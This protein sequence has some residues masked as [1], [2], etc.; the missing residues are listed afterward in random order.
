VTTGYIDDNFPVSLPLRLKEV[1]MVVEDTPHYQ[2]DDDSEWATLFPT[3]S[4]FVHL[5]PDYVPFRLSMFHQLHCL[6]MTRT[7]LLLILQNKSIALPKHT[8]HCLDYLRQMALCAADVHLEPVAPYLLKLG[9]DPSG[10]HRCWDWSAV[11]AE[12][13]RNAKEWHKWKE[14]TR[15]EPS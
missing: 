2:L 3:S 7:S 6:D 10:I 8:K 12:L 13:E 4:G 15:D 11:Y 9:V 14:V 5:G 1:A